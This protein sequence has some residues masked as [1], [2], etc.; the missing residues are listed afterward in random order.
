[1]RNGI[2]GQ[3]WMEGGVTARL[4]RHWDDFEWL[5]K[6]S[7]HEALRAQ[8]LHGVALVMI[9]RAAG[10]LAGAGG[11][12]FVDDRVDGV[13][14]ALD[15]AGDRPAA[16]RAEAVLLAVL[17]VRAKYIFGIGM[18]SRW[19]Y[20]QMSRSLQS[21]SACTR[22]CSPGAQEVVNWFQNSGG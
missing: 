18:P 8:L 14:L 5:E 3:D 19:M 4:A 6:F 7:L 10:A 13:G 20:I 9:L 1:M 12:E 11:G 21:S 15:R 2:G 22:T 17:A 16:E